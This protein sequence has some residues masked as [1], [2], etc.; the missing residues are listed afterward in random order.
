MEGGDVTEDRETAS[1]GSAGGGYQVTAPAPHPQWNKAFSAD[2]NSQVFH[3][4]DW[5]AGVCAAGGFQNATRLYEAPD[6]RQLIMPMVQRSYLGGALSRQASLPPSWGM[7]GVLSADEV[8]PEDLTAI[9]AD[10]RRQRRVLRTFIRPASRTAALWAAADLP[11]AKSQ[12]GLG[13]VLDLEGGFDVVWSKRFTQTARRAVRKAEKSGVVVE[14]DTTG[15]R[16]PEYFVL[17][18]DS[19]KRWAQQ[20]HEPLLLSRWRARHR[21]SLQK[22]QALAAAVPGSFRLYLAVWEGRPVAGDIVYRGTGARYTNGAMIKELAGPVRANF[23]LHR[24]AIE[25]ACT[26][27]STHFDFGES[28]DS[29]G[30]AMYKTRFGAEAQRYQAFTLERLPLTETDQTLRSVVKRVIGFRDAGGDDDAGSES[31]P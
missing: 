29:A 18:E 9:W 8:R 6:G 5:V 10:L 15:A 19:I 14:R 27:G 25:D 24:T 2:P 13:H 17:L 11:G 23:L 28:G 3:S 16:L 21:D 4:P 7:G 12:P 22:M 26:A 1:T 30:L 20:Q 31:R